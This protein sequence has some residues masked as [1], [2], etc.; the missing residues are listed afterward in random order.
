VEHYNRTAIVFHWVTAAFIVGNLL[1]GITMVGLPISP[2]KLH[3]YLWHKSTGLTIFALTSLRV[4]WRLVRPHPEPVPMPAWQQ[5]MAAASH[6]TLY[7]LLL[8]IPVSGWLYSSST[9]VQ[10]VYLGLLPLPDLVGKDKALADTLRL[11][12]VALNTL[13]VGVVC[14]HVA[15]A[16]KHHFVDRDAVLARMLPLVKPRMPPLVKRNASVRT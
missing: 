8:L 6:V 14:V 16:L 7:V 15:S 11:V 2:R 5:R 4:A 9:G 3:W 1:L 12:H 10:V 13:L